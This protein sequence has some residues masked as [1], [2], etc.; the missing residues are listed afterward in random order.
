[1]SRVNL[2]LSFQGMRSPYLIV[3]ARIQ[4]MEERAEELDRLDEQPD[5]PSSDMF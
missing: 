2:A 4:E 1:M 5:V 3:Q